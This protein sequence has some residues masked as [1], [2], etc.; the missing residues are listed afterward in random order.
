MCVLKYAVVELLFDDCLGWLNWAHS[1]R[2]L[3]PLQLIT[4][5]SDNITG[6]DGLLQP[7]GSMCQ[8]QGGRYEQADNGV[9]Y[10]CPG[11]DPVS[12]APDGPGCDAIF[13][14]STCKLTAYVRHA[15]SA[16]AADADAVASRHDCPEYG[17][18]T[19]CHVDVCVRACRMW[20]R[21]PW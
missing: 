10:D 6:V 15:L 14:K 16:V 4:Q 7:D 19:L 12:G 20:V 8:V 13:N 11:S 5:G 3:P 2:T 9:V 17:S 21:R 1:E 18:I